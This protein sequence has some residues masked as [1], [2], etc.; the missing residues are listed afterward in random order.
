[1]ADA[2]FSVVSQFTT[3]QINCQLSLQLH[4]FL[5][6]QILKITHGC[7]MGS[8]WYWSSFRG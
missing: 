4:I 6:L 8:R 5:C 1:M 2:N 3:S 7:I